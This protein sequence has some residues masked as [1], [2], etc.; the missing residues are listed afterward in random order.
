MCVIVSVCVFYLLFVCAIACV[1]YCDCMC[2]FVSACLCTMYVCY[3][4]CV[5]VIY[6]VCVSV[7]LR[8]ETDRCSLI[9]FASLFHPYLIAATGEEVKSRP[10]VGQLFNN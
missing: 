9:P 6:P 1:C 4:V 5:Y 2:V 8:F 3:R 7:G 10:S